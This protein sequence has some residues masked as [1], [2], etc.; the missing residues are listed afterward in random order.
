MIPKHSPSINSNNLSCGNTPATATTGATSNTP[1]PTAAAAT[2][3][4]TTTTTTATSSQ[5]SSSLTEVP[6]PPG[7]TKGFSKSQQRTYYCH[8]ASKHTQWHFPTATEA[9]DP[10]LAKKRIREV[11]AVAGS[12]T[13]ATK[14]I[15]STT[16]S[17]ITKLHDDEDI[18]RPSKMSKGTTA[19]TASDS[20]LGDIVG[21]LPKAPELPYG[22]SQKRER[23][24]SSSSSSWNHTASDATCVAIIAPYRDIHVAQ[25]RAKHLQQFVP[26]MHEFLQKQIKKGTL[27]DYHIYIVEQSNDNRKFNRGKLLNI[28]FDIARKNKCRNPSDP[29]H[30]VFIFHDVDLLPGDDLGSSYTKFPTVPLHIARVW[31]RYSNNPKYFGGIVSF[32]ESDMKRINGYPNTFWGWGGEDD[33]M[34][35]RCEKLGL[36]WDSPRKGTIQ[37]LENMNLQEKLTFLKNNR[38][39]KCMVKW[40]ALKEHESTWR[41]NGL[42]DLKYSILKMESLVDGLRNSENEKD[43]SKPRATKITVDVKLNG[44]HWSNEKSGM[45]FVWQG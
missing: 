21:V 12:G 28:G 18:A 26:Y 14:G 24:P 19:T 39:W 16:S 31:D 11:Q 8:A 20:L 42:A 4:T 41:T 30:D 43:D 25:N 35:K 40:E 5:S 33:E 17:S 38:N 22:Q 10:R 37:D 3:T 9:Q 2:T 29:K 36:S 13:V 6:L 7:W 34:Q 1:T 44:N 32:S 15:T 23:L 45:D 27:I